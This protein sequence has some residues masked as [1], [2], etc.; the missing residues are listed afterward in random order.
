M[1]RSRIE[2]SD[3]GAAAAAA[4]SARRAAEQAAKQ[5]AAEAARQAA[6]AAQAAAARIEGAARRNSGFEN[7][8]LGPTPTLDTRLDSAARRNS[9]F[10]VG[11]VRRNTG[12]ALK[13]A[14][15]APPTPAGPINGVGS[16]ISALSADEQ[17][18]LGSA[19]PPNGGPQLPWN[20]NDGFPESTALA[21]TMMTRAQEQGLLSP[22]QM[23]R[24]AGVAN[25]AVPTQDVRQI[26]A[27]DVGALA[28]EAGVPVDRLDRAQLAQAATLINGATSPQEQRDRVA[29]SL[30]NLSVAANG[31]L[32]QLTRKDQEAMLW[33]EAKVP[34]YAFQ[35]RS[36]A[37]V[38]ALFSD[39]TRAVNQ[40]GSTALKI[41]DQN[42]K[43]T[44]GQDGALLSST[45]QRDGF[46]SR[47]GNGLVNGLKS[48][49][50]NL[51]GGVGSPYPISGADRAKDEARITAQYGA[52]LDK[53]S[54]E[55]RGVLDS[56][57]ALGISDV[58]TLRGSHVVIEDGGARYEQWKALGTPRTSSHYGDVKPAPQQYEIDF[59]GVGP[60]LFGKDGKG[61][62]WFQFE[63]HS[64]KDVVPHVL[65]FFKYKLTGQNIGPAGSS[66]HAEKNDPLRVKG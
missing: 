47:L 11:A 62:T 53:L 10:E 46:L 33:A 6:A 52:A 26:S 50:L 55:L 56:I 38:N 17:R 24:S 42:L 4:E 60:M 7:K 40:P 27:L 43:L 39:V 21:G 20:R 13:V 31:T 57:R 61:N 63:G 48:V 65:D 25:R 15:L 28:R 1:S 54:P 19:L 3:A 36:N 29:L 49:A 32:P 8:A 18:Q 16:T 37:E 35:G 44:V 22:A 14:A 30:N 51:L 23:E 5:A 9:G 34:G 2:S 64:I 59:P 45:T 12:E 66:P 41:G 58:D